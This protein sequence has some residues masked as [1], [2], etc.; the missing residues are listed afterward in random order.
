MFIDEEVNVIPTGVVSNDPLY[1]SS[2]ANG[3]K[4]TTRASPSNVQNDVDEL[5]VAEG[6]QNYWGVMNPK[7]PPLVK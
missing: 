2:P 6:H 3:D 5:I 7:I 1:P 4:H